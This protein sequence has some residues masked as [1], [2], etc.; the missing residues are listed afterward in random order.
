MPDVWG[1]VGIV[2]GKVAETTPCPSRDDR[3]SRGGCDKRQGRDN[4]SD[5]NRRDAGQKF[6]APDFQGPAPDF[7]EQGK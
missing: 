7:S 2:R 3:Y 5:G 4:A 1:E 6:A